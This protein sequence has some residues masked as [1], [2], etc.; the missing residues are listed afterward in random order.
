MESRISKTPWVASV[1]IVVSDREASK[2][3]YTEKLGLV[4]IDN[5]DHWVT[6]GGKDEGTV[7]HLCQASENMPKP[8]PMEP[9][10]SGIVIAIPGDFLAECQKLKERGVEFSHP[11]ENAP[12]G[13]YATIRDP[14]GNEH[15]LAPAQ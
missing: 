13:W 14:D 4:L 5:Q 7:L 6:V 12:W 3:W 15:Y 2:K 8:I 9:G 11:P 10:P 1:P